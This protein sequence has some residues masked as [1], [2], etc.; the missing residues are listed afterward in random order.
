MGDCWSWGGAGAELLSATLFGTASRLPSLD[1]GLQ[2]T[3]EAALHNETKPHRL[4][5]RDAGRER[6][7]GALGRSKCQA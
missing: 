3:A 2:A 7:S 1:S 6:A 4:W 5:T